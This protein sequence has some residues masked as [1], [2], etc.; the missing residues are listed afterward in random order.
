MYDY[1]RTA[2]SEPVFVSNEV[3]MQTSRQ[4]QHPL[5]CRNCEDVL[6]RGGEQWLLPLL[7]TMDKKFPLLDIIE[8]VQPDIID[9]DILGYA[10]ARNP[11]IEV[12]KLIHFVMGVYWKASI[13]SW[14]AG[15]TEPSIEFGPYRERV[16][17]FLL[18]E[19]GFPGSMGLVIG[20]LPR[21]KAVI[22]FNHPYRASAEGYH[23]FVF[24]IPGI[25]T[26][27][28]VGKCLPDDIAKICFATNPNHPIVVADLSSD[29]SRV[30]S[31]IASTA[32]KSKKLTAYLDNKKQNRRLGS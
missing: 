2:D 10:A 8:R 12:D 21:G 31:Q 5:L 1:C 20:I 29:V 16:R 7:A 18:G 3:M 24:Y 30:F 11:Q 9:G 4:A 32:R 25:Q 23:N 27:L 28:S 6:N 13:H 22:S 26:V 15:R 14:R 17:T 19:T